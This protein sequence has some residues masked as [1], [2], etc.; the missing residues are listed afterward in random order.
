MLLAFYLGQIAE[1]RPA[2]NA[3][4]MAYLCCCL[5][6]MDIQ[7]TGD[8]KELCKIPDSPALTGCENR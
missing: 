5:V 8:G 6:R 1:Q 4:D 3:Y 2:S 7:N